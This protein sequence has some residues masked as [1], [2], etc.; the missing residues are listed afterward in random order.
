MQ[1]SYEQVLQMAPDEASVSAGKKLQTAKAW[2]RLGQNE[3]ALWGECQGSAV[4]QVKVEQSATGYKC[5][6]PSRKFPCKHVLGLL[7]LA[8]SN[9]QALPTLDAPGWV[10][11]WLD[12]RQASAAKKEAKAAKESP[13]DE[14]A[15]QK[16]A[17]QRLDR[18][19]DGVEKLERWLRDLIRNGLAGL[20]NQGAGSWEEQA[21]RL[22][23][24]QAPGL[25]LQLRQ[26]GELPGSSPDWPLK[27]LHQMGRLKLALHAF[28][29]MDQ[30]EPALAY[31]L[32]QW[33]G[34]TISAEELD[35]AGEKV[36]DDWMILG[37]WVDDDD[38]IRTQRTWCQGKIS[39]RQALVL[40]FVAGSGAFP[41]SF[42]PGTQQHGTMLFYPGASPQRAQFIMRDTAIQSFNTLSGHLRLDAF[43]AQ[44]ATQWA[45]QPW[46]GSIAAVLLQ[47]TLARQNDRW[48]LSDSAGQSLPLIPFDLWKL[49]AITGG[50]PFDFVGEWA[51][52]SMRPLGVMYEGVYRP[53]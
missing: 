3:K 45:Q 42:R 18:V 37:Q 30:L 6:C 51:S 36:E 35:K 1:L 10:A 23:D 12:Q 48:F 2:L 41:V 39:Q 34:W 19:S 53:L 11:E 15:Q 24:A 26:M 9:S 44:A 5:S 32:R 47:V 46:S 40:Q 29:R 49:L 8:A 43:L 52:S 31:S 17:E 21:K 4:Y 50:L 13:V 22:I 25:A 38:R 7:L 16:R 33:M 14:K 28:H 27:L 20:E